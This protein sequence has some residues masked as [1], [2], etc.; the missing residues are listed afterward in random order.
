MH[1][2]VVEIA[3]KIKKTG[4]Q[5]VLTTNYSK[6][7]VVKALDKYIDSFNISF[8]NQ[9]EL[10]NQKDFTADL[11][12]STLLYKGRIDSKEK[13]DN[14]I[15]EYGGR[16]HLKFATLS[17]CNAWTESHQESNW[18]DKLDAHRV[19]LDVFN[20]LCHKYTRGMGQRAP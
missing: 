20:N 13:L 5:I 14:F 17:V 4:F 6:P 1:P 9:Q 18:L 16:Y 8:Y 2:R 19:K 11:T 15:S 3:K 7:D 10:P 12:L